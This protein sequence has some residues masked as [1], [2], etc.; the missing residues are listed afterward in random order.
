MF[1]RVKCKIKNNIKSKVS[2]LIGGILLFTLSACS[3]A[4]THLIVAPEMNSNSGVQYTGKQVQLNV[5]DMRTSN[6]V[7]QIL[8]EGKA[9]TILSSQQ[10][11]EEIIAD[12]LTKAW[13]NQGLL[14]N[15]LSTNKINVII[16]KAVISVNQATMSYDTQSEIVLQVKIENPKQTLTNTF[17]IRSNSEGIL[18]ADIAVLERDFNQQLSHVL[19]NI[20]ASK[21]IQGF[22]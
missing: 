20:L 3:S 10:R 17:K 13:K 18:Q 22:L 15:A 19:S 11:L 1:I 9:A 16:D 14:F 4:P 21:D 7:V 6:H 12:T 5:V 2:Y 8:K